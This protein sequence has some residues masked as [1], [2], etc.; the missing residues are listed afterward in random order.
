MRT[1]LKI[2]L[3]FSQLLMRVAK[4]SRNKDVEP[5][6][7]PNAK[8]GKPAKVDEKDEKKFDFGGIPERN[9]KKNLGC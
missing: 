8:S 9:F 4:K 1:F 3:P 7:R 2:V 6:A 5:K